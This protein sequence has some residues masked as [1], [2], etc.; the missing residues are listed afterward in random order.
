MRYGQGLL[1]EILRRTDLVQLVGRRVKL[2]RRGRAFW[3]LCPFHKEK[4]PSFKVENER[5]NYKCFGCGGGGDAF[6]WLMETEGLSFP[7]A[8]ER[9]AQ[10]AG[11]DLPKWTPHGDACEQ[12]RKSLYS[13][14]EDAC[15][16]FE[17]QL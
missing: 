2:V 11:V 10:A 17:H 3:G 4:S 15:V 5:C 14:V 12:Q 6:K 8:V 16:Y 1:E 13:V 7:E 9:L